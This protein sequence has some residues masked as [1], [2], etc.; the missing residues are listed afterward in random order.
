M[1]MAQ[2]YT[3]R[4]RV[5]TNRLHWRKTF[6]PRTTPSTPEG[7]FSSIYSLHQIRLPDVSDAS[8]GDI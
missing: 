3:L 6:E 5:P 1:V 8:E 4:F 7:I 2:L